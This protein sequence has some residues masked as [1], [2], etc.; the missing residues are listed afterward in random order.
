MPSGPSFPSIT[1]KENRHASRI[2]RRLVPHRRPLPRRAHHAPRGTKRNTSD[3]FRPP[4][5]RRKK[6]ATPISS[7]RSSAEQSG[8]RAKSARKDAH[9]RAHGI[10]PTLIRPHQNPPPPGPRPRTPPP[11]PH[12]HPRRQIPRHRPHHPPPL[13]NLRSL[14]PHR[15]QPPATGNLRRHHPRRDHPVVTTTFRVGL[16]GGGAALPCAK[17]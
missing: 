7:T 10:R 13:E 9:P 12:R 3:R 4:L 6:R 15:P 14:L 8:K 5:Q 16:A 11:R 17:E 1:G 2:R